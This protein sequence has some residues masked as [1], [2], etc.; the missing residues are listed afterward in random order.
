MTIGR[1]YY[2]TVIMLSFIIQTWLLGRQVN[3]RTIISVGNLIKVI[4]LQ[5]VFT[6][7]FSK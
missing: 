6:P 5:V 7:K 3:D 4:A 1:D 2:S